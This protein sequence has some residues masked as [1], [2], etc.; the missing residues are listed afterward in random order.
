MRLNRDYGVIAYPH[1]QS[2][3]RRA[4][5]S[6]ERAGGMMAMPIFNGANLRTC[7]IAAALCCVPPAAFAV[8]DE[9]Q[10]YTGDIEP[11]G[12]A[13]LTWHNNFTP[14]GSTSPAE[15]G[16]VVPNHSL[17]GVPEWAYGVTP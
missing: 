14:S 16:G 17:N 1:G 3:N 4:I 13:G 11:L 6:P 10:V 15:P 7:V 5:I 12:V 2:R 8:T 9:I